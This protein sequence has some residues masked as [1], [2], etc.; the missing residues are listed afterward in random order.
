MEDGELRLNMRLAAAF[1]FV[2]RNNL[3][4]Q[5]KGIDPARMQ[6]WLV[7][8]DELNT[9]IKSAKERS[10]MLIAQRASAAP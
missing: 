8:F 7:N 10:K 3:D 4:L 5:N 9:A 6:L 1:Y 2:K